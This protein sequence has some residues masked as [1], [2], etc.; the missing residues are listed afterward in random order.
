[1]TYAFQQIFMRQHIAE[2][3]ISCYVLMEKNQDS[4]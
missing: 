2:F 1:M 4:F 3:Y